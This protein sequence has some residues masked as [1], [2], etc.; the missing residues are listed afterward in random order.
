MAM[1]LMRGVE[2]AAQQPDPR[3]GRQP[4]GGTLPG[5]NGGAGR[6]GRTCPAP[7]TTY[8]NVVSCSTPTGP[9]ACSRPV[10]MP[11]SK[12]EEH[13]SEL[14]ALMRISNAVFCLTKKKNTYINT[15]QN[16]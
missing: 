15:L 2:R 10:E 11:I 9:R 13:T 8:L 7:R 16:K 1:A 6:Q 12:S 5:T 4:A 3:T 14:Q